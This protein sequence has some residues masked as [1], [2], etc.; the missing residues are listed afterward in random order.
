MNQTIKLNYHSLLR[1]AFAA[2]ALVTGIAATSC[3]PPMPGG[4]SSVSI[5]DSHVIAAAS[6]AIAAQQ[7]VLATEM[8]GARLDLVKINRARSQVVAG[9]N[10]VLQLTVKLNGLEQPAEATVWWQ[11]WRTP[12]PYQLTAWSWK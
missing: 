10:Y 12:D 5:S 4:F 3:S 11:A 8:P 1:V 7:K 6:F 2:L 9:T